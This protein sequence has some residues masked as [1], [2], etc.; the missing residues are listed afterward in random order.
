MPGY[1]SKI[2][3]EISR[4]AP[5]TPFSDIHSK[6]LSDYLSG[7]AVINGAETPRFLSKDAFLQWLDFNHSSLPDDYKQQLLT[8]Y[9]TYNGTSFSPNIFQNF[10][11]VLGDYSSRANFENTRFTNL[12]AA[13]SEIL[14]AY[15]SEQYSDP[16]AELARRKSA[17][18]NDDINGGSSIGSGQPGDI[19]LPDNLPA[20]VNDMQ[21]S[22]PE[23]GS[24]VAQVFQWQ[25]LSPRVSNLYL[26]ALSV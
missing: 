12:N 18:L 20:P 5:I 13:I 8:A 21:S 3:K 9:D 26:L 15:H 24:T 1:I 6:Q 16:S 17:G 11:E 10:G 25:C 4:T 14:N 23:I 22:I 2:N 19:A 7:N